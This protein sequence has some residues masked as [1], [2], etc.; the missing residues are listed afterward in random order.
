MFWEEAAESARKTGLEELVPED[1]CCG[2]WG[3]QVQWF[4]D[5]TAPLHLHGDPQAAAAHGDLSPQ[6]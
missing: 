6:N 1:R 5:P 2:G 3:G 4:L